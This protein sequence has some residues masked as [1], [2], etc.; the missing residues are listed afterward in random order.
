MIA[1]EQSQSLRIKSLA[2]IMITTA[3][4]LLPTASY[5]TVAEQA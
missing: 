4:F 1:N 2:L 5:F 3:Y